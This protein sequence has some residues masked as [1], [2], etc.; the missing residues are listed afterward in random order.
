MDHQNINMD[1]KTLTSRGIGLT[2]H[3]HNGYEIIFITEGEANFTIDN[4]IYTC[5]KNN[6]V[7]LNNLEKHEM[8]PITTPYSRYMIIIDSHYLDNIIKEPALL[9]I[10]KIRTDSFENK[11]EV[12][13]KHISSISRILNNLSLIYSAQEEF[14]HI[15]FVSL[16]SHLIIFLYREYTNQFPITNINKKDQRILDI[17][18]YIDEN[19]TQNI[20]LESIAADFFI[21]KYYL[22]HS[23]KNITGF[24]LNQYILLKRISHAKNQLYFT[25][26]SI[27]DIAMDC[28]FNSQ[29]NFIRIFKKKEN[30]T[31]LQFRKYYRK[32]R[33]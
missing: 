21:S 8:S 13:K 32:E 31:P 5:D 3:F 12:K 27:T 6:L 24:T 26:N 23:Y 1:F 17:Q 33:E 25:D 10:F 29:S 20:T 4:K 18:T 15:E 22:A 7:F 11:F 9:S 16:L 2:E 14:W 19:F 30:I 28:G